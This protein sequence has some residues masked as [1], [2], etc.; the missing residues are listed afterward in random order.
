MKVA[1]DTS[2]LG[3]S[4]KIRG[5]GMHSQELFK[6]LEMYSKREKNL[7]IDF[8]DF[9]NTDLSNYDEVH[10]Q[11]FNPYFIN[12]PLRKPGKI[13]QTIHDL[14]Y[15]IYPDKYPP[16]IKGKV[17]FWLQ[18][19]LMKNVDAIITISET[20]KKDIVRFLGVNPKKVHVIYLAPK[21]VFKP[22]RKKNKLINIKKKYN[23]PDKFVLY[24]G[25]VNYN[26]N[27]PGLI[28]ACDLAKVKLVMVGKSALS[29]T[30]GDMNLKSIKGPRDWIRYLFNQPH[31]EQEHFKNLE[32]I[33]NR[34]KN[35]TLTGFVPE[36]DI[37]SIYNLATVYVQPSFYEGFGFVVV[38]AFAAGLPVVCSR[39]QALVEVTDDACL[40]AD[41]KD[42][43]EIANQ[44]KKYMKS[45]KL[46]QKYIK[47]GLSRVKKYSWEKTAKQVIEVYK[48]LNNSS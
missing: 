11:N 8:V 25:D 38:E 22:I 7:Q 18:K 32:K 23:L 9:K 3:S 28:E 47:R 31:P 15:L 2:V 27:I 43:A 45:S 6:L 13:I 17:K 19:Y 30:Q 41:P 40:Y 39:T 1:V 34:S 14:I 35:I 46:R 48:S 16:G 36:S 44:I 37:N 10:Y 33:I 26:K 21:E 24:V 20:S 12:L 5:I 4:H 29:L 42:P